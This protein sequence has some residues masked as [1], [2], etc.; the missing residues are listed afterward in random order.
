MENELARAGVLRARETL[1]AGRR[2]DF[3]SADLETTV[4][5]NGFGGVEEEG[6]WTV[7]PKAGFV[8]NLDPAV[9]RDAVMEMEVVPRVTPERGQTL[10]VQCGAGPVRD[11]HFPPG[12]MATGT[13]AFTVDHPSPAAALRV[14][15]G[16]P[17]AAPSRSPVSEPERRDLGVRVLGLRL[18]A[19]KDFPAG[20]R[21]ALND[22]EAKGLVALT[23]FAGAEAEGRWTAGT[24]AELL[25]RRPMPGQKP[26]TL[27]MTLIPF[28]TPAHGQTLRVR[29]D[30][31]I[32]Q[33]I[34]FAPGRAKT[35][36]ISVPIRVAAGGAV[37]QIRLELPDAISPKGLGA[38]NDERVL[39]VQVRALRLVPGCHLEVALDALGLPRRQGAS[40]NPSAPMT[41]SE[42]PSVVI[43]GAGGHAKVVIELIRAAGEFRIV[44]CTDPGAVARDVLGVPLLGSDDVLPRVFAD[45][46]RH[47]F[48]AVGDNSAR[49]AL[50]A[51]VGALGFEFMNAVSPQAV[52]SPSASLGHGI[53]I[54]NGAILNACARARP[55]L[56]H[57]HGLGHRSRLRNRCGRAHRSGL[58]PRRKHPGRRGGISGRRRDRDSRRLDRREGDRRRRRGGDSRCTGRD[59]RGRCARAVPGVASPHVV[60]A[61]A[62]SDRRARARGKRDGLR[63]GMHRNDLDFVHRPLYHRV[64]GIVRATFATSSTPSRSTTARPRCISRWSRLASDQATK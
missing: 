36:E 62:H 31:G 9:A 10:R 51:K 29:D 8:V 56:H 15:L 25:L 19:L 23:G 30:L 7:G 59:G 52:V 12:G 11:F 26:G 46:T 22:A 33:E 55:P 39:G 43:V 64:R 6:R 45:G 49:Q 41:T 3:G 60:L 21:L 54:M 16:L 47:A 4:T 28:V 13:I 57:Q 61:A 1:G 32:V 42:Q 48:L 27:E 17:E 34:H 35:T 38:G 40:A 2:I 24:E 44:G 18:V 5:V 58:D 37:R 50:A 20:T 53:A 63:P 14:R